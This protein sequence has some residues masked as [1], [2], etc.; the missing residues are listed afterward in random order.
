MEKIR[1]L[2]KT[3]ARNVKR[4]NIKNGKIYRENG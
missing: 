1:V 2:G 3:L 4:K